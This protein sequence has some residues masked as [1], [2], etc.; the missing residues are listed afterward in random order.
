MLM[1]QRYDFNDLRGGLRL[2]NHRG[3][4]RVTGGILGELREVLG[5]D[6]NPLRL[7]NLLELSV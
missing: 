4:R 3:L 7:E 1:S 5:G 2:Q 6:Q